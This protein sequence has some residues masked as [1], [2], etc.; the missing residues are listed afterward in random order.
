[1]ASDG[2][3]LTAEEIADLIAPATIACAPWLR[4]INQYGCRAEND[5]R[6]VRSLRVRPTWVRGARADREIPPPP[7]GGRLEGEGAGGVPMATF[8][9]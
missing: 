1:M 8:R 3:G 7:I 2:R 9:L 5:R 4:S 6:I